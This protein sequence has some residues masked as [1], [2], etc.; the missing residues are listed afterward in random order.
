VRDFSL[1]Q[2]VEIAT[3]STASRK[4][5]KMCPDTRPAISQVSHRPR[6]RLVWLPRKSFSLHQKHELSFRSVRSGIESLTVCPLVSFSLWC[7]LEII[8]APDMP[9][10]LSRLTNPRVQCIRVVRQPLRYSQSQ[11]TG[12]LS[13]WV[14]SKKCIQF[15]SKS[16]I[17][18]LGIG[19]TGDLHDGVTFG[20]SATPK[21]STIWMPPRAPA[22]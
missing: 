4:E 5:R 1:D 3:R 7:V 10:S 18:P 17:N 6:R 21:T 20:C 8:V 12:G 2:I 16:A 11:S 9:T 22:P 15:S 14:G 13:A 19:Q